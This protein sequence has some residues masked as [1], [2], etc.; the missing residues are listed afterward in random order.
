MIILII[1]KKK[2]EKKYKIQN[3]LKNYIKQQKTIFLKYTF[4][5][6]NYIQNHQK[7]KTIPHYY[8]N[9]HINTINYKNINQ[10]NIL[11]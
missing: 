2:L 10:T 6:N 8:K 4:T 7:K 11:Q 1:Y 5:N 3:T 9:I